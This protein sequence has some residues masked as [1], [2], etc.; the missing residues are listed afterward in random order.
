MAVATQDVIM[1]YLPQQVWDVAIKYEIAEEF[2]IQMP[3]LIG[4]VL[5][6]RSIDTPEDKQ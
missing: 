4:L 6:S 2:I 1:K 5:Q 3:D